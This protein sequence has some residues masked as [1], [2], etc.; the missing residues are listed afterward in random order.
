MY[1]KKFYDDQTDSFITLYSD[2]TCITE[3]TTH[4]IVKTPQRIIRQNISNADGLPHYAGE[5]A[6]VG[7]KVYIG[8]VDYTWKQINNS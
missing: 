4:T 8:L 3:Y 7:S 6:V 5:M 1:N 2:R